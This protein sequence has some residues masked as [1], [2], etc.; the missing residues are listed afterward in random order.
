MGRKS[1]GK[2]PAKSSRSQKKKPV[3]LTAAERE[4]ALNDP[5]NYPREERCPFRKCHIRKL[6]K[7]IMC[8]GHWWKLTSDMRA[9]LLSARVAGLKTEFKTRLKDA[10][11]YLK[12]VTKPL[13]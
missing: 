13:N 6:P 8:W 7:Q 5:R 1:G 10:L 11:A 12:E 4:K 3:A 2:T 9:G